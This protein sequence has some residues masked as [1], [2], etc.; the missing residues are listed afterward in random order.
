[1][2][3]PVVAELTEAH[4]RALESESRFRA[5]ADSSLDAFCLL[6]SVPDRD[7]VISDFRLRY[8]NKLGAALLDP[9]ASLLRNRDFRARLARVVETGTPLDEEFAIGTPQG[10][11]WLH[12]QVVPQGDGVAVT[13]RDITA[14][15]ANEANLE[16]LA[17]FDALT[18]LAN[19]TNFLTRLQEEIQAVA[20]GRSG[21]ML[22]VLYCDLDGLKQINDTR[23]HAEGDAMLQAFASRLRGC[24]RKDDVVARMGGD[25][26]TALL[27]GLE[28][29]GEAKRAIEA[30][31]QELSAP[32]ARP[33][34]DI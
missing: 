21:P 29:E 6:K 7:G 10:I 3:R 19:R 15:K 26:F 31:M 23:G 22:A 9:P 13:V 5:A 20:E 24:V 27:L 30:F 14:R 18:G 25:E 34:G 12:H 17:R 16:F 8:S 2:I 1:Q 33:G 4:R 11:L 32:V 28:H